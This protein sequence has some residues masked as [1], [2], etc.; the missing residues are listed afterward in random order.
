MSD[1]VIGI[2]GGEVDHLYLGGIDS[3]AAREAGVETDA[4]T[5]GAGREIFAVDIG[6]VAEILAVSLGI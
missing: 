4:E 1:G 5:I 2:E 3:V 6:Y